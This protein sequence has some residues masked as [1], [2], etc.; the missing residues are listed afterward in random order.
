MVKFNIPRELIKKDKIL[1]L[2]LLTPDARQVRNP[3]ESLIYFEEALVIKSIV[4]GFA[5]PNEQ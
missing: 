5:N 3:F 4:I 1:S 2:N